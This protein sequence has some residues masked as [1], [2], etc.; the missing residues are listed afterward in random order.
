MPAHGDRLAAGVVE[1][2]KLIAW[3]NTGSAF[4]V[5]HISAHQTG[6]LASWTKTTGIWPGEYVPCG[7]CRSCSAT[8]GKNCAIPSFKWNCCSNLGDGCGGVRLQRHLPAIDFNMG[9]SNAE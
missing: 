1:H 6:L 9:V 7:G 2:P 4:N 8:R 3:R 5:F